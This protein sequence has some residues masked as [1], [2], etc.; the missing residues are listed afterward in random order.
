MGHLYHDYMLNNQRVHLE[1]NLGLNAK[2]HE[3]SWG[4]NI[5]LTVWLFV[6]ASFCKDTS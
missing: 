6:D 1:K 5:G 4:F 2:N 3:I